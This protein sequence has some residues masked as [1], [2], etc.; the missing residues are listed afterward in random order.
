IM[1]HTKKVVYL[2]DY[3]VAEISAKAVKIHDIQKAV[4]VQRAAEELDF[5]NEKAALGDYPHFMLK[6]I[7]EAPQTIQSATRGRLRAETNTVKLGGLESVVQQLQFIDRIV[8]VACGTSYYAGLVGEYL[9]E[10]LSGIPVE[11]QLA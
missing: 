11:V 6:E 8:I 9:I 3:E 5:D 1:D 7:F 2:N 4:A 10:E